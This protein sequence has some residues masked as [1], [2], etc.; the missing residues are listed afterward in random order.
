MAVRKKFLLTIFFVIDVLLILISSEIIALKFSILSKDYEKQLFN[1]IV[2]NK[3][4]QD[5]ESL[6]TIPNGVIRVLW[7]K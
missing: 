6:K 1:N 4:W 7:C 5:D 3:L 2:D